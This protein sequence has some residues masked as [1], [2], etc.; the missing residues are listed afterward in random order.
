MPS[1]RLFIAA[2]ALAAQVA[3]AQ[4]PASSSDAA[5]ARVAGKVVLV[6]GDALHYDRSGALRSLRV[7]DRIY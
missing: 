5:S 1:L 4:A 2:Y 7:G 6:E 3:L